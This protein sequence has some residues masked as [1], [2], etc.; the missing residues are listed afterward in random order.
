MYY[1][2]WTQFGPTATPCAL[3]PIDWSKKPIYLSI[4]QKRETRDG[5]GCYATTKPD[6]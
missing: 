1:N 2:G 3:I 4:G 5:S 6:C